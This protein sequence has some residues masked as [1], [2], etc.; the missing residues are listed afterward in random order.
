MPGR[1]ET[2]RTLAKRVR[3]HEAVRDAWLAKSFTDRILVVD[4]NTTDQFPT[5]LESELADHGLIGVNDVYDT[6]DSTAS[7]MGTLDEG[8]RHQ[9]VDVETRGDHQSYVLE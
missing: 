9:F 3:E 1:T 6:E 4:L 8:T 5:E 7:S 2:L